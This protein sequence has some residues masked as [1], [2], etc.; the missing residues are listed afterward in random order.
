MELE[1]GALKVIP[2]GGLG[3]FGSNMMVYE[4]A[5]SA[6]IVDCGMAFPDT[7][8]L[9]VDVLIPDMDYVRHI[10]PKVRAVFLTH[11]HEDHIGALPFL[12]EIIRVPVYGTNLTLA[13]LRNKLREFDLGEEPVDLRLLEPRR[14]VMVG[15]IKVEPIHV[16]HSIVDS[17]ALAI[18]TPAGVIVHTGD[19]K[20]DHAPID[21]RPTDLSRLAEY[22]ER[23][24]LL[25]VS[26][27]TNAVYPGSSGSER[28]VGGGL[29]RIISHAQGR[30]LITTFASHIHRVQQCADLARRFGRRLYLVGRSLVGNIET[31][32]RLGHIRIPREVRPMNEGDIADDS[33]AIVVCT[34]S[35]GEP[36]S[37]LARI[38]R[39]E[40]RAIQIQ[41]GDTV[42]FS[43]RTIPGNDRAVLHVIDHLLRRGTEVVYEQPGIHVSGHAHAEELK[44]MIRLTRPRFFI[45]MHGSLLHLTRH[46][47][48]AEEMGID[49]ENVFVI[50]NGE[51]VEIA[52]S[53]GQVLE[54]RVPSGKLFVDREFEEVPGVV[55]RDRQH[56]AE[57]GFVIVVAAIDVNT[58]NLSRDPEIITRG[59]IHVDASPEIL[60]EVRNLLIG[61]LAE[62]HADDLRDIENVQEKMRAVLKRY[63]RKSLNRRPMILPVVWEM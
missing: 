19:F 14:P 38:A 59:V 13:F 47:K 63:F 33:S 44:T 27:S 58:G 30:V 16:T 24:V 10:A 48:L 42:V 61:T 32:E 49:R 11:G 46:A 8:I 22:G 62:S 56:L 9:G 29:E 45:P 15:E 18:E 1:T 57:D 53:R 28:S 21:D 26:D 23:G 12:A 2:L 50:T 51:V 39:D 7:S 35:Q 34:G 20:F 54:Q 41:R 36:E 60:E 5:G 6:I 4:L 3:E 37:A 31:A 43:S 25:L 52:G 40:H 17:L 55:V